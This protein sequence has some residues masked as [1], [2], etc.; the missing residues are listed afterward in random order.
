ME[1]DTN[2]FVVE[3]YGGAELFCDREEETTDLLQA[4]QSGRNVSLISPRRMGKS[5]LILHAF[6]RVKNQHPEVTTFYIDIFHTHNLAEFIEVFASAV[7]KAF[8]S[9]LSKFIDKVTEVLKHCRPVVSTDLLTG[10]PSLSLGIEPGQERH[11]LDDIFKYLTSS[12]QRIYI[13]FDEFQQVGEYPETGVEAL[14]RSYIQFANNITF[15]YSGSKKHLMQQMFTMPQRPFYQSTQTISLK[16]I[17]LDSYFAFAQSLFSK[18][19]RKLTRE[20]FD[21][22]YN[23]VYG[24]TWYVQFWLNR[25]FDLPKDIIE[26][27]DVRL[28]LDKILRGED[29]NFYGYSCLLTQAQM[30]VL[31][32]IAIE[33]QLS[34]PITIDLIKKYNLPAP[35][36]VRSA[37][38]TLIEKEFI[39]DNR[40]TLSLYNRFFLHWLRRTRR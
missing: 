7:F 14:L 39:L 4:M 17:S 27:A 20:A 22:I 8:D 6:E 29:D 15:I 9:K 33:G 24:H 18:S 2:P 19:K 34:L 30:A 25:I 35:S 23:S 21:Y 16:E 37:I 28:V 40:G 12:G 5:G 32:A 36:T 3:G 38:K 11:T 13:A 31:T 1:M 10:A 26:E